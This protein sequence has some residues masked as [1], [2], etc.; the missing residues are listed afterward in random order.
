MY[1]KNEPFKT[2]QYL[3][4]GTSNLLVANMDWMVTFKILVFDASL[5][6]KR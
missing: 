2:T 4:R 6:E 5:F 1:S 3:V